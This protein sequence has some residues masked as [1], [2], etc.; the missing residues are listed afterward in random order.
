MSNSYRD[1]VAWQVAVEMVTDVYQATGHFPKHELY[2]LTSQIRRAAVS[3]PSNVAEGQGRNSPGE[4]QQFLGHAK[5]SLV[6][7]ETQL[8]I[9]K[10]LKYL[11]QPDLDALLKQSDRVS[12]LVSGLLQSLKRRDGAQ[13]EKRETRN[14]K[15]TA[16]AAAR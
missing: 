12:R 15:P 11:E 1:L 3:V 4:F 2:G 16:Q 8:I 7:M 13:V 10:N 6:E 9:A 5:G 14:Q